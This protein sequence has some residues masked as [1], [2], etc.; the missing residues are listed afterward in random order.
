MP[1][2]K[3]T[4]T[5]YKVIKGQLIFFKKK[6]SAKKIEKTPKNLITKESLLAL[7]LARLLIRWSRKVPRNGKRNFI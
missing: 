5:Y 4:V 3:V 2:K 7:N 1:K 6:V